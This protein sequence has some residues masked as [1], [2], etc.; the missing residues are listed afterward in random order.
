MLGYS[1][2]TDNQ[3]TNNALSNSTTDDPLRPRVTPNKFRS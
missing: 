3:L 1:N 2:G